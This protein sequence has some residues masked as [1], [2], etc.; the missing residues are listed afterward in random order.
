MLSRTADHLF[1]M[2]RYMERAENTARML[3]VC[4]QTAMLPQSKAHN[5]QIWEGL[6]SICELQAAY[7]QRYDHINALHVMDFMVADTSNPSSI[8]SCLG[9]AREN[10][11][12]VR[13]TLA[14]EVWE[15][16]NQT[17]LEA[18]SHLHNGVLHDEPAH[19]FEWVKSQ[20][21][22]ARGVIMGTMPTDAAFYFMRLGT[23]IERGDNT[24]RLL[25]VRSHAT[26][27]QAAEETDSGAVADF[28]HWSAILRSLSSYE[29][30]RR[31]YRD[32]VHGERVV[33]LLVLH[34][35]MPRSLMACMT[36]VVQTLDQL[37][38]TPNSLSRRKAGK[39]QAQLQYTDLQDILRMG[40]HPF[41]TQYLY[42]VDDL[43][44]CITQE[45]LGYNAGV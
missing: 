9:S 16:Y 36:Y 30:Y 10:A 1:W 41:L 44:R 31:F 25:D 24:A 43:G 45:F 4:R 33:D 22:L 38:T 37:H 28:Y 5:Q 11:R 21:H 7:N 27:N 6:L 20:S 3:D 13:G 15:T 8:I 18:R 26:T 42:D 34:Q 29:T 19:F 14:T 23:F 12:A 35:D 32:V 40:L 2:S 39:L 17:W